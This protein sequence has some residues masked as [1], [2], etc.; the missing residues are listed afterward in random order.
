M[1]E[2]HGRLHWLVELQIHHYHQ[3]SLQNH[4][5]HQRYHSLDPKGNQGDLKRQSRGQFHFPTHDM[6]PMLSEAKWAI[7]AATA[8]CWPDHFLTLALLDPSCIQ[9]TPDTAFESTELDKL[10]DGCCAGLKCMCRPPIVPPGGS[11]CR[12]SIQCDGKDFVCELR[13]C[14]CGKAWFPV[15]NRHI[16]KLLVY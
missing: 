6:A 15:N 11:A 1:A 3:R 9:M 8:D 13:A 16:A 12:S 2:S 14:M 5:Q 7:A 4:A 10:D